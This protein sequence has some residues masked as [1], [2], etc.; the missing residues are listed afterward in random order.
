MASANGGIPLGVGRFLTETGIKESDWHGKFWAP[1]A[2]RNT[3]TGVFMIG[4]R[5]ASG[6]NS[7]PTTLQP[8]GEESPCEDLTRVGAK[9]RSPPFDLARPIGLTW[10]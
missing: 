7:P 5:M 1:P 9:L 8:S 2:L 10:L 6:S 3:G 4:A